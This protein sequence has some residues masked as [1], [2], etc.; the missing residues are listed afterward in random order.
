MIGVSHTMVDS[1]QLGQLLQ[2]S[3]LL[4]AVMLDSGASTSLT[5][6]GNSLVGYQPRPVPHVVALLPPEASTGIC[7]LVVDNSPD[8]LSAGSP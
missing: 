5:Y 2:E 3:G 7:P 6:Q 8:G 1:I 4:N